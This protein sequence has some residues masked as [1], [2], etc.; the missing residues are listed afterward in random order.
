[1]NRVHL[2]GLKL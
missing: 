2:C 1:M